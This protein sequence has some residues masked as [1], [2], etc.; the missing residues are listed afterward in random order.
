MKYGVEF[1]RGNENS[2]SKHVGIVS[3]GVGRGKQLGFPTANIPL[4]NADLSG[5][6]A[7]EV[8]VGDQKYI[9]AAFADPGRKL[10][11]AY[12]LD[13]EGDLYGKEIVIRLYEKLRDR[14]KF[15]DEQLLK[16][17]IASDIE[18]VRRLSAHA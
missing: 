15:P 6:Y 3:R 12:I 14:E 10:L 13:F 16:K 4:G 18:Q 11:E 17:A 5:V 9:A 7:A 1:L 8:A 2:M